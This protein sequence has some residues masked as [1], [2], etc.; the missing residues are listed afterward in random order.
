VLYSP[1]SQDTEKETIF[2]E[3]T[4]ASWTFKPK[5][6]AGN[7]V[8]HNPDVVKTTNNPQIKS[9]NGRAKSTVPATSECKE[10]HGKV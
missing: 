8:C 7:L 2:S 1:P 10:V 5:A 6:Q 4:K 3:S 9:Q